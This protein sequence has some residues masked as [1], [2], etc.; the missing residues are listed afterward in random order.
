MIDISNKGLHYVGK[1]SKT[2]G[3]TKSWD[4]MTT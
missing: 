1:L 3:K 4:E 2:K